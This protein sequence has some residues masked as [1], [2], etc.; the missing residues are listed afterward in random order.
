MALMATAAPGQDEISRAMALMTSMPSAM[1]WSGMAS[2]PKGM[3][4]KAITAAGMTQKEQ[5]GMA[6]ALPMLE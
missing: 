2:S 3:A 5:I 4:K 6:R 1:T